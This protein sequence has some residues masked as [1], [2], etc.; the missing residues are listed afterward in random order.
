M[1]FYDVMKTEIKS[2]PVAMEGKKKFKL[3]RIQSVIYFA[4]I[5]T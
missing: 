4:K 1:I 5:V 2:F 3:L